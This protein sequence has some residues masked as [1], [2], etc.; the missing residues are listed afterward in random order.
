MAFFRNF[1][2]AVF[3]SA[4]KSAPGSDGFENSAKGTGAV[5]QAAI[6]NAEATDVKGQADD[7]AVGEANSPNSRAYLEGTFYA[8]FKEMLSGLLLFTLLKGVFIAFTFSLATLCR[9]LSVF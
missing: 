1:R 5:G 6:G 7:G 3:P 4:E 9:Q 2:V 8:H